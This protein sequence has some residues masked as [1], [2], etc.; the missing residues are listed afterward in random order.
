MSWSYQ[1]AVEKLK[2]TSTYEKFAREVSR[3]AEELESQGRAREATLVRKK[4]FE[5]VK[6]GKQAVSPSRLIPGP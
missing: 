5:V 4:T 2:S 6:A 1:D 3:Y